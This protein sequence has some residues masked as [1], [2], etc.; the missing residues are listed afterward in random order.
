MVNIDCTASHQ[1]Q[2]DTWTRTLSSWPL[3]NY[4]KRKKQTSFVTI[5]HE[6]KSVPKHLLDDLEGELKWGST[7]PGERIGAIAARLINCLNADIG[8]PFYGRITQQGM[9][10]T[11][12]TCLTIPAIKEALRRSGLVGRCVLNSYELGPLC[13]ASD[14]ETPTEHGVAQNQYFGVIRNANLV[15]WESGRDG[16]LCTNV[17]IQAY[18]LLLAFL[19]RYWEQ[20][21]G[22]DSREMS[23]RR[24]SHRDRRGLPNLL[25]SFW[26]PTTQ[27]G[28]SRPSRSRSD[29][30]SP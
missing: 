27:R 20:E 25:W 9:P 18:I 10:T 4:P 21:T 3:R 17:A 24:L 13:G 6:Q 28:S 12:K 14:T 8:E 11:N 19:I 7:V 23:G 29:P 2:N 5:N 1:S 16:H 30:A 26:R 22:A 15:E